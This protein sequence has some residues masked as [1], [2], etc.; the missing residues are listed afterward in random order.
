PVLDPPVQRPAGHPDP[1][2]ARAG[3]LPGGQLADHRPALPR[4]QRRVGRLPD[5]HVPE[6]PDRPGLLQP[7]LAFLL[8]LAHA[9]RA[10]P[11]FPSSLRPPPPGA[12][13]PRHPRAP[14]PARGPRAPRRPPPGAP[15]RGPPPPPPR[16][17]APPPPPGPP[18]SGAPRP[19][20]A[21]AAPATAATAAAT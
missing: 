18:P 21:T 14:R 4:G 17:P 13:S 9:L 8:C 19:P 20:P 6:Q 15:R 16:P 12:T 11:P 10:P 1:L 5:Q 3:V 7:R 2:P